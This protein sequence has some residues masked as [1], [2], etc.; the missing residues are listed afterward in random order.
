VFDCIFVLIYGMTVINYT[1]RKPPTEACIASNGH[2]WRDLGTLSY[3]CSTFAASFA[4]ISHG[5]V[6]CN[7]DWTHK[8][9]IRVSHTA[10]A[11][12]CWIF[13]SALLEAVAYQKETLECHMGSRNH[14]QHRTDDTATAA[15]EEVSS[16]DLAWEW[17]HMFLWLAWVLGAVASGLLSRRFL[18][19]N[20]DFRSHIRPADEAPSQTVGVPMQGGGPA[21]AVVTT[22]QIV[23]GVSQGMPVNGGAAA[24]SPW[25]QT[26]NT[27][28]IVD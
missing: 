2:H 4:A 23:Q 13:L 20:L 3:M 1:S 24:D 22:G 25:Q 19:E 16:A 21:P 27:P 8:Q 6:S 26:G 18:R 11:L 5:Q 17:I 10:Y 15:A 28:K 9:L 12:V 14:E 7:L